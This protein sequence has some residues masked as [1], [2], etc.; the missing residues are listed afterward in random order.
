[1][2]RE[3]LFKLISC[4][5]VLPFEDRFIASTGITDKHDCSPSVWEQNVWVKRNHLQTVPKEMFLLKK[6]KYVNLKRWMEFFTNPHVYVEKSPQKT[7]EKKSALQTK[8]KKWWLLDKPIDCHNQ[9]GPIIFFI[10]RKNHMV[11]VQHFLLVQGVSPDACHCPLVCNTMVFKVRLK[12]I[13][14]RAFGAILYTSFEWEVWTCSGGEE[15]PH[16]R[17]QTAAATI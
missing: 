17:I 6:K 8:T 16:C 4:L 15:M 2:F 1:M 3:E 9:C 12:L 5:T 10:T 11:T 7:T 14:S 13:G